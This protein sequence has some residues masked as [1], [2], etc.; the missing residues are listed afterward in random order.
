MVPGVFDGL[1]LSKPADGQETQNEK[2]REKSDDAV[3]H[4]ETTDRGFRLNG[5]GQPRRLSSQRQRHNTLL[6]DIGFIGKMLYTAS[7]LAG[8]IAAPY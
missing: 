4:L 7:V 2:N 5:N 8:G 3:V 6:H 1:R